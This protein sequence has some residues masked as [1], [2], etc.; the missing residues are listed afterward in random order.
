ML[1]FSKFIKKTEVSQQMKLSNGKSS[2]I[3]VFRIHLLHP[4]LNSPT[5]PSAF[6][7]LTFVTRY[8][9]ISEPKH[10]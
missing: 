6:P 2:L 10:P 7:H 3:S 8:L 4:N 9:P 1:I 5:V